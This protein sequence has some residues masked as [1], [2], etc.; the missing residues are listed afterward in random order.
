MLN[1]ANQIVTDAAGIRCSR[2]DRAAA[3]HSQSAVAAAGLSETQIQALG[4][5]PSKF[6]IQGGLAYVSMV[7][8]DAAP[9]IQDDWKVRPNLTLSLGLRYEVQNLVKR[10]PGL[11][12]R[13]SASPG[14]PAPPRTGRRKL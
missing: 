13:A 6:S 7:R 1:S 11:W 10:P 14:L 9:F 12:R 2:P 8:W 5:G 3:V 4:G